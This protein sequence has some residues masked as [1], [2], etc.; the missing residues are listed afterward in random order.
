MNDR[1]AC[2]CPA[3]NKSVY[4]NFSENHICLSSRCDYPK[5]S[6][7]KLTETLMTCP[8]SHNPNYLQIWL[9]KWGIFL[10][11]LS[12]L[13]V[14]YLAELLCFLSLLLYFTF[15]NGRVSGRDFGHKGGW[16]F[17]VK[18][19]QHLSRS[20]LTRQISEFTHTHTCCLSYTPCLMAY[21]C[22]CRP[23]WWR[24]DHALTLTLRRCCWPAPLP[25]GHG[26][27]TETTSIEQN[28]WYLLNMR[29]RL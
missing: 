4:V 9:Q 12:C 23:Y 17:K 25:R 7:D 29:H 6:E 13:T 11:P 1:I 19:W 8:R 3:R 24:D 18:M 28:I 10:F 14:I 2:L 26:W 22:C 20:G 27:N 16:F 15:W 21:E 5:F